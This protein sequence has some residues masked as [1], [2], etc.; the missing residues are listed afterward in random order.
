MGSLDY[1]NTFLFFIIP[2][3]SIQCN[4][5]KMNT[6]CTKHTKPGSSGHD[7]YKKRYHIYDVLSVLIEWNILWF[8]FHSL[9]LCM[10]NVLRFQV[11]TSHRFPRFRC[12]AISPSMFLL[13]LFWIFVIVQ[14]NSID[15]YVHNPNHCYFFSLRI[16]SDIFFSFIIFVIKES[17]FELPRV[18]KANKNIS[19]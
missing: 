12:V 3:L 6:E 7:G 8:S 19:R 5:I 10:F 16:Q 9:F 4:V 1:R 2:H 18:T 15:N 13:L 11:S 17:V 14:Y